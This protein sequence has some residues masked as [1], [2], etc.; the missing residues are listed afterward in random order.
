[1]WRS[2]AERTVLHHS[3]GRDNPRSI[4]CATHQRRAGITPPTNLSRACFA[5]HEQC[6]AVGVNA[7]DYGRRPC[8]IPSMGSPQLQHERQPNSAQRRLA[9]RRIKQCEGTST[10][11]PTI[12]TKERQ[13]MMVTMAKQDYVQAAD[14][15]S[16]AQQVLASTFA[17]ATL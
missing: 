7:D 4:P 2:Q 9:Y 12:L 8:D 10:G 11:T 13:A 6:C 3:I 1:M 14:S 16:L 5:R 17:T 15:A